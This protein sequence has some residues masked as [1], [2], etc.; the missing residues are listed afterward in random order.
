[1]GP[2]E[3][4]IGRGGSLI[5]GLTKR[6]YALGKN[7]AY[8]VRATTGDPVHTAKAMQELKDLKVD[9]VVAVGYPAAVAAKAS[10]I[11]TVLAS[12]IGDP[13]AKRLRPYIGRS[14]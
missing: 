11:P 5:T 13:V 10:G 4:T 7:L 2:R 12:G 1:G 9:I 3:A 14:G 8:E 6:G